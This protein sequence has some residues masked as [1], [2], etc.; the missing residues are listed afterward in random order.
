MDAEAVTNQWHMEGVHRTELTMIHAGFK[1]KKP[2][3]QETGL[4]LSLVP[5]DYIE[6]AQCHIIPTRKETEIGA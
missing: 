5:H 3:W 6:K 1:T 2:T 4:I